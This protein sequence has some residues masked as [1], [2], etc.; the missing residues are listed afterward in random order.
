[1]SI[2]AVFFNFLSFQL[3]NCWKILKVMWEVRH[4]RGRRWNSFSP[5]LQQI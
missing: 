4:G 5:L 3:T 2:E 1:L